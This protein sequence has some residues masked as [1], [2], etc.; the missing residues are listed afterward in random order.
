MFRK[1]LIGIVVLSLFGLYTGCSDKASS[2]GGDEIADEFGGIKPSDEP[3]AFGDETIAT[4]MVEDAEYEDPVLLSPIVEQAVNNEVADLYSIRIVWG[5]LGFDSSITEV[6]D[7][8]GSLTVSDGVELLR[9]VIKFEDGQDYIVLRTD[10]TKIDWVSYTTVHH[11][12]I[13]A[14]IVIPPDEERAVDDVLEPIT[15]T[16]S[17]A[18]FEITF[19]VEDLP[20]LDTIYY[21]D[22]SSAVAFHACKVERIACPRGFLAGRWGLNEDGDG[23]FYG[24]WL[25]HYDL[26]A[27]H[28]RGTWGKNIDGEPENV[29]YGKYI[30]LTGSFEGL[31]RGRYHPVGHSNAE[32]SQGQARG[33]HISRGLFRGSFFDASG[34]IQGVLKGH[35]SETHGNSGMGYFQ[36][37]WRTYCGRIDN[38]DDGLDEE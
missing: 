22:D 33:R 36:G 14:N 29:F 23:V 37:R 24:K 20:A 10:P 6:T 12:G 4:E 38:A 16:F 34:N 27:G 25:S 21:L 19:N 11:D 5:Q 18:P 31:L 26:L 8:S 28:I 32:V 3:P 30:D 1:L 35:Y 13:F 7:W 17:T 15:V 2:A 9:R